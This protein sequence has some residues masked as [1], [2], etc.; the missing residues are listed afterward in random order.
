MSDLVGQMRRA[1]EYDGTLLHLIDEAAARI[2]ALEA[3][4]RDAIIAL[5]WHDAVDA[6]NSARAALGPEQDK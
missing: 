2:E 1:K 4:L 5:R 6:A 3:A